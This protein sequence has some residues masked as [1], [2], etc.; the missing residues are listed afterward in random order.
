VFTGRRIETATLLLL[1]V[2]V[3]VRM[4]TDI[5]VLFRNLATDCLP[6]IC[7]RGKL[8]TSR[9]LAMRLHVTIGTYGL[10]NKSEGV[11]VSSFAC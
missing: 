7:L 1:P 6:R 10:K 5:P 3:A 2:L 9:C 11:M 4:F 8:F